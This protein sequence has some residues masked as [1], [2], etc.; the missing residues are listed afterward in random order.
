MEGQRDANAGLFPEGMPPLWSLKGNFG[1][2][3]GATGVLQIALGLELARRGEFPPQAG[4]KT[5]MA[6]ANVSAAARKIASPRLWSFNVG[7]G[8]LN[9]VTVLEAL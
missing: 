4:L 9:S 7:F 3:L 6:G 1:H 2:T 8:G 5:P